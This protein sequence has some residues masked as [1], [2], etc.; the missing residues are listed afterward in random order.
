LF[1]NIYSYSLKEVDNTK[2]M[3][4]RFNGGAGRLA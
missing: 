4:N 1:R 2:S 3:D